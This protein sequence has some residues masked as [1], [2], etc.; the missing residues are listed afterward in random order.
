MH[1][2]LLNFLPRVKPY[3][4]GAIDLH[5]PAGC[6][7]NT[8]NGVCNTFNQQLPVACKLFR[9]TMKPSQKLIKQA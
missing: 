1:C 7:N 9:Y 4:G 8:A 2:V 6:V 3:S 5:R